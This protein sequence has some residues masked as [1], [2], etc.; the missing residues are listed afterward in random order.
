MKLT[1]RSYPH[2][3]VGNRDDVPGAAF[4][5]TIEMTSDR[6][7]VYVDIAINCSSA[8]INGLVKGGDACF[9]AHVECGNTLFRR[10]YD[11]GAPT[12]RIQIPVDYLNDSVEV[13]V[14]ARA[15]RDLSGYR[16]ESA[17]LD[18]GRD[19]FEVG[20]S[21]ILA[22]AEGQAFF[23]ESNFDSLRS[24]GSIMAIHEA[25]EDG[26]VP[27]RADYNADKI[28]IILS[29][30]DF[31]DYK[32]LKP[33]EGALVPLTTTI[34]LPVLLDAIRFAREDAGG[35]GR[36]ARILRRRVEDAGL[37]IDGDPLEL[38]QQILELPIRR[39]FASARTLAERA[40]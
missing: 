3:V 39:S 9:V 30:K 22:V 19:T 36:W 37:K 32:L 26:D 20:K 2:P 28:A 5:A 7:A 38:A 35:E 12:H 18:Y 11:F 27:M 6:L 16:V 4:Q 14:F 21:N 13:N 17:H 15:M 40:S 1:S 33:M 23:I 24:I 34:V 31:A 29:K 25:Q 10:A 8:T